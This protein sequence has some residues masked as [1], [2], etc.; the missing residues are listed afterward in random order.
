MPDRKDAAVATVFYRPQALETIA[1][2]TLSQYD[3]MY[4]NGSP[5]AVPIE[6]IIEKTF[7]LRMQKQKM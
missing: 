6:T 1:R 4:L 3:E 7:G 5:R 2:R